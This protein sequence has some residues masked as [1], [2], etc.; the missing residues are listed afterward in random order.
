MISRYDNVIPSR[1]NNIEGGLN[2]MT[3]NEAIKKAIAVI[4]GNVKV[5][6]ISDDERL[7]VL[8]ELSKLI[9]AYRNLSR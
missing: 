3:R 7:E 1:G 4:E 6:S 2:K 5:D 9:H 8:E